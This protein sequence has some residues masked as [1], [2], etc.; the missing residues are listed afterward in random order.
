MVRAFEGEGRWSMDSAE[1][2][3]IERM[4]RGIVAIE[5][6][7]ASID[8]KLKYSQNRSVEDR[9]RVLAHLDETSPA[10]A[11]DMRAFYG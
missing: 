6:A 5:I 7:V 10:L 3:Y 2:E 1:P 8:G 4:K 9:A 11:N